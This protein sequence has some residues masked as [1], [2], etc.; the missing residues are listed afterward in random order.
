MS[1]VLRLK[2]HMYRN[3]EYECLTIARPTTLIVHTKWY[4]NK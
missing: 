1:L 3:P 4:F 2:L